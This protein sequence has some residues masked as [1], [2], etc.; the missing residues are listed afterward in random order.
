AAATAA[1]SGQRK[2]AEREGQN[3]KSDQRHFGLRPPP[4]QRL[5]H[6]AT[7]RPRLGSAT[8]VQRIRQTAACNRCL[9]LWSSARAL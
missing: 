7:Q 5:A 4:E 1:A 3:A 8:R 6:R 9:I 2:G